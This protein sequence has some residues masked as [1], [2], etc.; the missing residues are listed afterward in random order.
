MNDLIVANI[1][2]ISVKY[3]IKWKNEMKKLMANWSL[4]ED[5]WNYKLL[6]LQNVR[7][8]KLIRHE[9]FTFRYSLLYFPLSTKVLNNWNL[10]L[11]HVKSNWN[12]YLFERCYLSYTTHIITNLR[13]QTITNIQ[14]REYTTYILFFRLIT[15]KTP[16]FSGDLNKKYC[17]HD[18]PKIVKFELHN[19]WLC[20]V[21]VRFVYIKHCV[22]YNTVTRIIS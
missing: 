13:M 18:K 1:L 2:S 14:A 20:S 6:L 12:S 7:R 4:I 10:S 5:C 9:E 16:K 8:C 21:S 15:L 17:K 19:S 3:Y 11:V 22:A